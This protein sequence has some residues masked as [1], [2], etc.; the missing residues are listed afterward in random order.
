MSSTT[1]KRVETLKGVFS[2]PKVE[3][4]RDFMRENKLK[5]RDIQRQAS[6]KQE[7]LEKKHQKELQ[8]LGRRRS[9][10]LHRA[11]SAQSSTGNREDVKILYNSASRNSLT[12]QSSVSNA[13]SKD[14]LTKQ[15]S[16]VKSGINLTKSTNSNF[17]LKKK[18]SCD[19][20]IQTEDIQDEEFL[21]N[22]LKKITS[23]NSYKDQMNDGCLNAGSNEFLMPETQMYS[24]YNGDSAY[25]VHDEPELQEAERMSYNENEYRH[26]QLENEERKTP[27]ASARSHRS[28]VNEYSQ[29]MGANYDQTLLQTT[30]ANY[31]DNQVN[32]LLGHRGS[33]TS[34]ANSVKLRN[35]DSEGKFNAK[36][37]NLSVHDQPINTK[38]SQSL[39]GRSNKSVSSFTS[40]G[41]LLCSKKSSSNLHHGSRDDIRLPRYLEKEKRE[42]EEQRLQEMSRDPD[43]PDDHYV[44]SEEHRVSALMGA[45]KKYRTLIDELNSLPM[46]TETLRIRNRKCKIEKELQRVESDIRLFSKAKVYLK[47]PD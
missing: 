45:E 16:L 47:N 11:P 31:C 25:N 39:S 10:S 8:Y 29:N 38:S 9:S 1:V 6:E 3:Y 4:R 5:L 14:S 17:E 44:L 26:R 21:Y 33:H 46:T 24:G 43:C 40:Q 18:T 13:V 35:Q 7:L 22:A 41:G 27:M 36:M 42:K 30:N 23:S 15:S 28:I 37:S 32:E 2:V 12:K 19:K 34:I 20:E